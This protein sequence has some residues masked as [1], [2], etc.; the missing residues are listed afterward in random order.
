MFRE[1][2]DLMSN[3]FY[4]PLIWFDKILS[5]P[6]MDGSKGIFF[7][8]ISVFLSYQLLIKPLRGSGASDLA[9]NIKRG[10][11]QTTTDSKPD[12]K[13]ASDD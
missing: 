13:P 1:M 2:F 9:R 5:A 7:A 6:D 12:T 3:V 8:G 11:K 10:L 4:F